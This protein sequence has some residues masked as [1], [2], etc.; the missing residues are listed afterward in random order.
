MFP[1]SPSA[2]SLDQLQELPDWASIIPK[3]SH[4]SL[5]QLRFITPFPSPSEPFGRASGKIKNEIPLWSHGFQ[6]GLHYFGLWQSLET[7]IFEPQGNVKRSEYWWLDQEAKTVLADA[8]VRGI[9]QTA[10]AWL[11]CSYWQCCMVAH[12]VICPGNWWML[13]PGKFSF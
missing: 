10:F 5:L 6:I 9:W 11:C 3:S 1:S 13:F 12:S 7:L 2:R 8:F 4:S